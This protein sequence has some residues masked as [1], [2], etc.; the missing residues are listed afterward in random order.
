[1]NFE[2]IHS[3]TEMMEFIN[4][5]EALY[6]KGAFS[7]D[8]TPEESYQRIFAHLRNL[9]PEATDKHINKLIG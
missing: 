1:M 2:E 4:T 3:C 9:L 6:G 8:C 5:P 7:C